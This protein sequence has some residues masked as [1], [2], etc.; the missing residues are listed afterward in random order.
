MNA[1]DLL[2]TRIW[3]STKNTISE[4]KWYDATGKGSF[5]C[6][7]L[8][9]EARPTDVKIPGFTCIPAGD[10][11][12]RI[13][14]SARFKKP[15]PLIYNVEAYQTPTGKKPYVVSSGRHI[16]E[17]IRI[18]PGNTEA[19]TEGCLLPGERGAGIV[20]N[21]R[22]AYWKVETVIKNLMEA[23]KTDKLK[24]RIIHAQAA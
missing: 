1:Y 9:D 3:F 16:W 21:S 17:G 18:H 24:L 8:E 23:Q 14:K 10:Y 15:L 22:D 19:D 7:I 13:T 6:H 2:L 11:F 20:Q 12:I 4:L 5:L